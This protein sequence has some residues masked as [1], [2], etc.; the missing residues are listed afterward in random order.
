MDK[1]STV[2]YLL[3]NCIDSL[4]FHKNFLG[5][6]RIGRKKRLKIKDKEF[7]MEWM[8]KVK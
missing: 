5:K 8:S 6:F 4:K 1:A 2:F 7:M 3:T